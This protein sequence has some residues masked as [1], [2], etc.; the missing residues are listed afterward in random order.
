MASSAPLVTVVGYLSLDAIV[1]PGGAFGEVP[2]GAALYAGLGAR[3]AGARVRLVAK[4]CAD[5]PEAVL[6]GL[7]GLGIDLGYLAPARGRTRRARLVDGA[8]APRASP[9]Y[10][11][12]TWWQRTREL[13]PSPC[14]EPAA[15]MVL[16]PMPAQALDG[17]LEA[18]RV[19]GALVVA[20]SSEA[21]AA[22]EADD[23]LARVPRFDLFAPSREEVRLLLP[24]LDDLQA[25]AALAG[26]CRRVAQKLGP[27]GLLWSSAEWPLR[28][29]PSRARRVVDGTGAGDAMVGALAAGLARGLIVPDLLELASEIAARCLAGIGPA[30]LGLDERQEERI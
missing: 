13:A 23:W 4:R 7:T 18:A 15:A 25:Q 8:A 26:R 12:D 10:Q 19:A 28:R 5:F 1:G 14:A 22:R 2:G 24:G 27:D 30:G 16:G 6:A 11:E 9:H 29:C 20:D 17:H 3:A 21:F